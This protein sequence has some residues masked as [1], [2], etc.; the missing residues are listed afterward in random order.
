M[1]LDLF[2]VQIDE[3]KQM[4][5]GMYLELNPLHHADSLCNAKL[6]HTTDL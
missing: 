1:P 4:L 2:L 6:L 5:L 3:M